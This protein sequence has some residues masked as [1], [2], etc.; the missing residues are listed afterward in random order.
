MLLDVVFRVT[1][2]EQLSKLRECTYAPAPQ[3]AKVTYEVDH[4]FRHAV[5]RMIQQTAKGKRPLAS[6]LIARIETV[7]QL[8]LPIFA[9]HFLGKKSVNSPLGLLDAARRLRDSDEVISLRTWLT[10]YEKRY[11]SSSLEL[12]EKALK[13]IDELKGSLHALDEDIDLFSVFRPKFSSG[14]DGSLGVSLDLSGFAVPVIKLLAKMSRRTVFLAAVKREL[15]ADQ[16]LGAR[17]CRIVGRPIT[18]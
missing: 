5:A 10:K 18:G 6:R 12:K 4:L 13:E 7:E 2:N 16:E 11:G 9:I 1:I 14:Q 17:I 3:R 15:T 8:P